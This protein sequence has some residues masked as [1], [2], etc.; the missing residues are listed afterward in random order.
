MRPSL[1]SDIIC[2]LPDI[3]ISSANGLLLAFQLNQ[4]IDTQLAISM[5]YKEL[6]QYEISY[7]EYND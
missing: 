6:R 5:L 3:H 2:L 4:H 1:Y 7:P